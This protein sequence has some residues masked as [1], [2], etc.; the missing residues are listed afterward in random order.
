MT[1]P[2]YRT[3]VDAKVQK[4]PLEIVK[5]D[6][7][8]MTVFLKIGYRIE[9]ADGSWWLMHFKHG[10]WTHHFTGLERDPFDDSLKRV[11]RKQS[12]SLAQ[13]KRDHGQKPGFLEALALGVQLAMEL[14]A[15][16]GSAAPRPP[17]YPVEFFALFATKRFSFSPF[18][19]SRFPFPLRSKHHASTL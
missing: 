19:F 5:E 4:F 3:V 2:A 12:Y 14:E 18:L 13:L 7:E 17:G 10:T 15:A 6:G 1:T 11:E 8:A 9:M 16:R